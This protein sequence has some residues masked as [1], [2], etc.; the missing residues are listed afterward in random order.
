ME[1]Q[2]SLLR[3]LVMEEPLS[4]VHSVAQQMLGFT[5]ACSITELRCDLMNAMLLLLE[6]DREQESRKKTVL[7]SLMRECRGSFHCIG[8]NFVARFAKII[9]GWEGDLYQQGLLVAE[10]LADAIVK[11][12]LRHV[13]LA[14]M[15][16]LRTKGLCA[17]TRLAEAHKLNSTLRVQ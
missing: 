3:R 10:E 2:Q 12:D 5:C 14:S 6:E 11:D 13:A 8:A 15:L 16:T 7:I 17:A 4:A 1:F 9:A